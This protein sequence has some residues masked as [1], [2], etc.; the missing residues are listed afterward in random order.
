M[1]VTP[2]LEDPAFSIHEQNHDLSP[3]PKIKN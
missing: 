2:W 3:L 1:R